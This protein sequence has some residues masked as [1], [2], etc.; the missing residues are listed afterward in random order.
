MQWW[1]TCL[2]VGKKKAYTSLSVYASL[3]SSGFL[4]DVR[5]QETGIFPSPAPANDRRAHK[6][7]QPAS[8]ETTVPEFSSG[9]E[10]NRL[11]FCLTV[12]FP[13]L[14]FSLSLSLLHTLQCAN[15]RWL[16][17]LCFCFDPTLCFV[18]TLEHTA[19]F[20]LVLKHWNWQAFHWRLSKSPSQVN[21]PRQLFVAAELRP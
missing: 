16:F 5:L 10:A 18:S 19:P 17:I 7:V 8:W 14:F 15:C 4:N 13:A 9:L 1:I 20:L 11:A 6:V 12:S 2:C 3:C 21:E